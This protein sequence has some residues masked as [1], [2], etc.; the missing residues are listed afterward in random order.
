LTINNESVNS[1]N[2]NQIPDLLDQTATP[3]LKEIERQYILK[4][5]QS[6]DFNKDKT[7]RLLGISRKTLWL[8]LKEYSV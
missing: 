2:E 4:V 1:K 7:A 5:L 3:T 8:K 6:T